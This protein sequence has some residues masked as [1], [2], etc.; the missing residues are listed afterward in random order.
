TQAAGLLADR[1]NPFGSL[2]D[3]RGL[4]RRRDDRCHSAWSALMVGGSLG[5]NGRRDW[6]L[7]DCIYG[8]LDGRIRPKLRPR[9]YRPGN[10]TENIGVEVGTLLGRTHALVRSSFCGAFFACRPSLAGV[11]WS[12][13]AND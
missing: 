12:G 6:R 10:E 3:D 1:V 8:K 5:G 11:S 2:A 9:I 13:R 7:S 4:D